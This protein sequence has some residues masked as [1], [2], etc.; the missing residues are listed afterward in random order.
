[1]PVSGLWTWLIWTACEGILPQ[2]ALGCGDFALCLVYQSTNVGVLMRVLYCD[3]AAG[4]LGDTVIDFNPEEQSGTGWTF[5]NCDASGLMHATGLALSTLR[6][7]PKDF[8]V[9][10][11]GNTSTYLP[12]CCHPVAAYGWCPGAGA[13]NLSSETLLS[14]PTASSVLAVKVWFSAAHKCVL[15]LLWCVLLL[16]GHPA[17]WHAA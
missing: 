13:A 8:E 2:V 17:A 14:I 12:V 1:M 6:D 4:G 9:G 11:V 5:G 15:C 3:V 7:Y 10:A 16:T